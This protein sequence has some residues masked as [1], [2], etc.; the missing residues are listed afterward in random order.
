MKYKRMKDIYD[1][2]IKENNWESYRES[3][4]RLL[5]KKFQFVVEKILHCKKDNFK[6]KGNYE[7]PILDAPIVKNLLLEA[8]DDESIVHD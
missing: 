4:E 5:R 8:V 2:I 7:I 6:I 1:E 3:K